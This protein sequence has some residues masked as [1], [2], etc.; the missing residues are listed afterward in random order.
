L[1]LIATTE[2]AAVLKAATLAA[3]MMLLIVVSIVVERFLRWS[4]TLCPCQLLWYGLWLQLL[5]PVGIPAV[6]AIP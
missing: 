5:R 4:I 1:T 2:V 3:M 6:Y